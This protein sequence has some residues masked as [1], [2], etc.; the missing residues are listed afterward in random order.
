MPL[1]RYQV[2]VIIPPQV[3]TYF[4]YVT[5]DIARQCV[6]LYESIFLNLNSGRRELIIMPV[7]ILCAICFSLFVDKINVPLCQPMGD[8]NERVMSE[9][10][11]HKN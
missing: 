8:Q 10:S 3:R 5:Y 1:H 7:V 11:Q 4:T 6:I 9:S 2:G